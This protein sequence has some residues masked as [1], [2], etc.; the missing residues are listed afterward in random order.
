[1]LIIPLCVKKLRQILNL[2]LVVRIT[3]YK[4]IFSKCYTEN[5]LKEIFV[6]DSVLITNPWT[7][8][9]KNLNREKIIG[10]FYEKELLLSKLEISYYPELQSLT[11][12]LRQTLAFMRN[13]ALQEKF[14]FCFSGDFY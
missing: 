13:K 8:R 4:N 5:C 10:S 14:N 3:K 12:Y 11:K 2:T 6:S 9:I 7:Y 1:M